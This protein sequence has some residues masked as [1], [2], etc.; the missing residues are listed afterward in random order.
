MKPT[1]CLLAIVPLA[2]CAPVPRDSIPPPTD[3]YE[4]GQCDPRPAAAL[5]GQKAS[6]ETGTRALRLTGART[7]RW[8]PPRTAF[9]MDYSPMRVNVM[10][11]DAM[12]ITEVTCG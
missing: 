3:G 7:L 5:V 1:A 11:D 10:Y 12:T 9:T 8:G 2:A 4:A 6:A